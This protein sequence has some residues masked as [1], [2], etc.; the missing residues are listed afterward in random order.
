M[1]HRDAGDAQVTATSDR[2]DITLELRRELL[3]HSD[4]L[5]ER[6]RPS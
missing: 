1:L 3:R 2:D 6:T 4:I 5:P